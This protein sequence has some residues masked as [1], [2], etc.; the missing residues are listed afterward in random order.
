MRLRLHCSVGAGEV[1]SQKFQYFASPSQ[2]ND[3]LR[4]EGQKLARGR[5]VGARR[6]QLYQTT[7]QPL[8]VVLGSS[9]PTNSTLG[10]SGRLPLDP[11]TESTSPI[12]SEG[13]NIYLYVS[14]QNENYPRWNF[15]V[16]RN[17]RILTSPIG[18][19]ALV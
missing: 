5:C 9:Y 1:V 2:R 4:S 17:R 3:R 11:K 6:I 19:R 16:M 14:Y 13:I 15:I 18:Q 8:L 7:S 12:S 10:S